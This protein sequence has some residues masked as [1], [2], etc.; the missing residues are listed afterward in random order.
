MKLPKQI[1]RKLFSIVLLCLVVVTAVILFTLNHKSKQDP[2]EEP[3]QTESA[4]AWNLIVVNQDSLVPEDFT[5]DLLTLHDQRVDVRIAEQL[6]GMIA[7]SKVDG[8]TLRICSSFR[9]VSDQAE[10]LQKEINRYRSRGYSEEESKE[11]AARFVQQPA[12]SEH[13]TG[14]AVDFLASRMVSLGEWNANIPAYLWLKANA[15]N[16]GFVERYPKDKEDI[17]KI[18]WEPWHYRFVGH[19]AAKEMRDSQLCLEEYIELMGNT[20]F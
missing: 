17:T 1:N 14:L 8:I 5:V 11:I 15:A 9:S 20:G 3:L 6:N 16:Y 2:L 13:H 7:A 4:P 10:L 18:G 12:A 19:D